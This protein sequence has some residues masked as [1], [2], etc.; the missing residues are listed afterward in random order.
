[1]R[2]TNLWSNNIGIRPFMGTLSQDFR[3]GVRMLRK[4]PSFT[5]VAVLTLALAIGANT[6][7]FSVLYPVLLRPLPFRDPD[8]LVTVG[9]T[10]HQTACCAYF[11]SYPDFLDWSRTAKSFQ[12]LAG[13][14]PDAFTLT[15][16]GDPKTMF[17]AM[18]TTNFFST[19]GVTPI[20]GR[21]FM[22]GEDLPEGSGPTVALL[23]YQFWHSDF[24]GDPNIVGRTIRLDG[25]PVSV[26]GVLPRN[27][28]LA[29]AGDVPVW[30]PL[31]NNP[32]LTTTR[33]AR[34]LNVIGRLAPGV[35]LE[36]ARAEMN[37]ISTQLAREYPQQNAAVI[38]TLGS[39]REQVV[40]RIRP[41]LLV[42]FG[43]V[44]FVLLIA[45]A[46]VANLLMSRSIDRR[47]EFAIRS[48]LGASQLHL[49]V[50]LLMESLLLSAMGAIIGLVG[51]AISVWVVVRAIPES[52]LVLM[53]YLSDIRINLPVLGFVCAVTVLTAILFGLGPG[54]SVPQ[55]PITE[56]LKDESRGGTSGTHARLRNILVVGEIAISLVLLVAGGLM[57]QS[58]RT[59]LQQ[60]P[61]FEPDHVLTF[62]VNLPG[63][64]YPVAKT[65][66][67]SNVNGLRFAHEFMQ[68]L[69]ALPGVVG[70]SATSALPVS[71]NRNSNRFVIEGQS[72]A[73]G[74]EDDSITRRVEPNYF[75]VMKIPLISGRW[76]TSG[77]TQQAPKVLIV[78]R[79]WAKRFLRGENPLGKRV[80]LTRVAEEPY[81]EIVGVVGDVAEEDLA[82]QPAPAMYF[83]VDQDSGY[84]SYLNYVIRTQGDPAAMVNSV[85]ATLRSIDQQLAIIQPQS[86]EEFVDRSSAVF[87]R[88]YPFYLIGSFATLALLL[89]MIGLYG[90]ISYSVLQRT[91]EIG[92][93]MSMGAQRKDILKLMLR[94]GAVASIAGVLIGFAAGLALTRVM[95]SLLYGVKSSDWVIFAT[96]SLL[97]LLIALA[98]SYIPARKAT[99]VDPMVALRNE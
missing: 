33:S 64:S 35:T 60:N 50:Q 10:R 4:N 49:A 31:H 97:L 57:L 3:Y 11:A 7:I 96:V 89:A 41:L 13:Y 85:R 63:A 1:M 16:N 25:R 42:L 58:L 46:N 61:G 84:T 14:S 90:L 12:S 80:R 56:V 67:F 74:E 88:R 15:G 94:Q 71:A 19:L 73:A 79:A 55:M 27:F 66:P 59:L 23:S 83:S 54:L 34:W 6:A 32:Y 51:A 86:M 53:P 20:L 2:T 17:C 81:G 8:R 82:V 52:Q 18:V 45:C 47:R 95:A 77:D 5:A 24:S 36:Q 72:V 87:L 92:I 40:G 29:P 22:A 78:N 43:A 21:D 70:V 99:A 75:A 62:L 37:G 68:R 38:V 76:F 39:L 98:A 9:E 44:T 28:Q 93:R 69:A 48:A 30:V 26:I 65:W 91:R